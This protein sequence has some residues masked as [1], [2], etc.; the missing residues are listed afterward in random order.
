MIDEIY[1]NKKLLLHG[2]EF[3][4]TAVNNPAKL[5]STVLSMMMKC[6]FGGPDFVVKMLPVEKLDAK[7][8]Y[9]EALALIENIINAQG[10]ILAVIVDGNRVK[11]ARIQGKPWLARLKNL[12][13]DVICFTI[14][15]LETHPD[16]D[17]TDARGT[18]QSLKA[19]LFGK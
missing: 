7:F 5:A 13:R 19:L 17:Q 14:A 16:I 3:F 2:G 15:A 12:D 1:V 9:S 10:D 18:I 8:Q 11:F 4:G 6:G